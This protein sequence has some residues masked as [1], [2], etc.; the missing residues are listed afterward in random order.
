MVRQADDLAGFDAR[1]AGIHLVARHFVDDFE[2]DFQSL[3]LGFG[4]APAG[5]CVR[6][7]VEQRHLARGV[8]GD[9][10]VANANERGAERS[11]LKQ[12]GV[13]F[14]QLRGPLLDTS[15]EF[16]VSLLQCGFGSFAG[17]DFASRSSGLRMVSMRGTIGTRAKTVS[18]ETIAVPSLIVPAMR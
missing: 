11:L 4:F 16:V 18:H 17:G 5:E 2:D 12:H 13:G 14:G 10:A 8:G 6:N 1:T 3:A 15:L 9:H 7:G